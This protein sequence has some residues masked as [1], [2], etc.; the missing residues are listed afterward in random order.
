V[1]GEHGYGGFD[2]SDLVGGESGHGYFSLK[3][4]LQYIFKKQ[5]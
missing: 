4:Y 1:Y 2:A 3:M 5:V